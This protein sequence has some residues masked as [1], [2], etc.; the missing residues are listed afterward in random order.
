M[1][2]KTFSEK[3]HK[4]VS[5]IKKH[6]LYLVLGAIC[7]IGFLVFIHTHPLNSTYHKTA[8]TTLPNVTTKLKTFHLLT[9]PEDGTAQVVAMIKN[10][11]SSVDLVMYQLQDKEV[12]D[13]LIAAQVR[14]VAVRV[15]VNQGYYDK[16]EGGNDAAYAYLQARGVPVHA[17]PTYFALTH[18]KTLVVDKNK[19]LIMTFNLTPKY[20]STGRDFGIIDTDQNDVNA[21][22]NVFDADWNGQKTLAENADDLVWSPGSDNDLLLLISSAKK[23]LDIYNEEM[24]D[25]RIINALSD[26]SGRGVNVNII[27]TYQSNYK[28]AFQ[29][30]KDAGVHLHLFHGEKGLYI[31]AKMI[32]ADQDYAFIGSEN[33]SY[34]SLDQNR[35]LGIFIS[36]PTI[37]TSLLHTFATDWQNAQDF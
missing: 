12:A 6:P 4:L 10:S 2:S 33:F 26:A 22:E 9:E 30:L 24:A 32:I 21:I 25:A 31:H 36:D 11:S 28:K 17:T 3:Y 15:L 20:Y 1:P 27:M 8:R 5:E 35:E 14:G 16:K 13:A 34:G 37:I 19:V 7:L 18:Q 23:E 29:E